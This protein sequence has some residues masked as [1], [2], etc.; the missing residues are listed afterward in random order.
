M[1][2][3]EG[4][5]FH[6]AYAPRNDY[7]VVLAMKILKKYLTKNAGKGR[8]VSNKIFFWSIMLWQIFMIKCFIVSLN[9]I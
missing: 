1:Y 8:V 9:Y 5:D 2:S 7:K 4:R 6:G 3:V